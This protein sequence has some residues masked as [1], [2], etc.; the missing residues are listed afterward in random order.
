MNRLRSLAPQLALALVI[1]APAV[2]RAEETPPAAAATAA[3]A[4]AAA[5]ATAVSSLATAGDWIRSEDIA[6]RADSLERRIRSSQ[7]S[8]RDRESV[9][10]IDEDLDAILP[11]VRERLAEAD[12]ALVSA[13]SLVEL[14]DAW[15]EL[16]TTAEPLRQ[17][18]Q[19]LAARAKSSSSLFDDLQREQALWAN[20]AQRPETKAAGD[21]IVA[22]VAEMQ[23]MIRDAVL[24]QREWRARVLAV[25]DHVVDMTTTIDSMLDKLTAGS[26]AAGR[27]IL[28]A[29]RPALW[30]MPWQTQLPAELSG[31]GKESRA[32]A[33]ET[34]EYLV[35]DQ[36]PFVVHLVLA[37][38]LMLWFGHISRGARAQGEATRLST[39]AVVVFERPYAAAL[40][41]AALLTPVLHPLAPR[42]L[43]QIIALLALIP[44]ARLLRRAKVPVSVGSFVLLGAIILLDRA[45]MVFG[46]LPLVARLC[47]DTAFLT[48]LFLLRRAS[49]KLRSTPDLPR[50]IAVAAVVGT[51]SAGIALVADISGWSVLAALL[52]RA[53]TIGGLIALYVYAGI[54]SLDA[55]AS[56]LLMLPPFDRSLVIRSD[57]VV[58]HRVVGRVLTAL[59]ILLWLRLVLGGI[60]LWSVS[61]DAMSSLMQTGVQIG[62]ATISIGGIVA[63]MT[64]LV[65]VPLIARVTELILREEVFPRTDLPRGIPLV[66][67]TLLRYSLYTIGFFVALSL[68]GLRMTELSLLFGGVGVGVGL[69]LQDVVKNFAAGI[70]MLLERRIQVG[71]ALQIP[72]QQ[73][74]GRVKSIGIRA[75]LVRNWDGAEVVV[76][77]SDLISES[78]TN[79]TL[80]DS[81]QR[82]EVQI[83]VQSAADP[84]TVV[85]LLLETAAEDPNL[86][87]EPPPSA[88][89][90]SFDGATTKFAL[91]A[92]IDA[93]FER[94]GG[95]RSSLAIRVHQHLK[96]AGVPLGQPQPVA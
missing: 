61:F 3:A 47:Q 50:W 26:E 75:T 32:F 39:R 15:R 73:V 86:L 79:W 67:S 9:E 46:A 51:W 42:R 80:S 78:V 43:N 83:G 82:I 74:F 31:L 72:S 70:S 36:R 6:D 92:W 55:A 68:A 22:R 60:G 71:D 76:P 85:A 29:S 62:A 56:Y 84:A 7:P 30:S 87:K 65:L 27:E 19:D 35:R 44:A 18:R 93:E 45:S 21:A 8:S 28:A 64:T 63:A 53:A 5:A 38:L 89:L 11:S 52:G 25:N 10:K 17:W 95:I 37:L 77:N 40:M 48:T 2:A 57:S 94:A 58:V 54:L 69:G 88:T 96:A 20:T 34:R 41:V 59:G 12:T 16:R 81:R 13:T 90:V 4:P 91:R 23:A 33:V 49:M 1:A 24:S 66:L 14:E